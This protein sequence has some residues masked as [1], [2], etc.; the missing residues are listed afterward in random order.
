[1]KRFTLIFIILIIYQSY[2]IAQ[3][4]RTVG[5]TSTNYSTLQAAFAAIN[6]GAIQGQIVLQITGS[7]TETI[8]PQINASGTGGANYTSVRISRTTLNWLFVFAL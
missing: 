8:L 1:M 6:S 4:T 2:T 7:T 3:T 5:G